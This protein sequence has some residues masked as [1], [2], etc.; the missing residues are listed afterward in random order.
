METLLTAAHPDAAISDT[1]RYI[2]F[3]AAPERLKDET[4]QKALLGY[5]R[6][7]IEGPG[8]EYQEA[9]VRIL[10]SLK[11]YEEKV[12][13]SEKLKKAAQYLEFKIRNPAGAE[14]V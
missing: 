13:T 4:G 3:I 6:K 12:T 10:Q 14:S 8:F 1:A 7:I 2:L 5:L 9:E 11:F